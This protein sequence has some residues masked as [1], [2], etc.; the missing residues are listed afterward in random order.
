[1][2][3]ILHN[4]EQILPTLS[5]RTDFLLKTNHTLN[6]TAIDYIYTLPDSF[7]CFLRRECRGIKFNSTTGKLLARPFHKFFNLGEKPE[8]QPDQLD[9]SLPHTV[10]T[11]LDGSMVHPCVL[12]GTDQLI[13]MTRAG[14]TDIA[15]KALELAETIPNLLDFCRFHLSHHQTPIFEYTAPD[16]RIVLAYPHPELTL[17]AL[18]DNLTGSYLHLN[19]LENLP[20]PLTSHHETILDLAHFT[21]T[22]RALKN[23]EGFVIRFESGL[24]IKLKA[25]DYVLRHRAKDKLQLEKNALRI[26][27]ENADDDLLPLLPPQDAAALKAYAADV[28]KALTLLIENAKTTLATLNLPD[29]KSVAI[30]IKGYPQIQQILI[31][32]ILSTNNPLATLTDYLIK[33]TSSGPRIEAIRAEVG[34]PAWSSYWQTR[35]E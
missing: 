10:M 24:T 11:K 25:D 8:T 32:N 17:L 28:R 31:F 27:L 4:I 16:N 23:S 34:L 1:M 5:G 21:T 29:R 22:T 35:E 26:V 7:D 3:P 30:A 6:I 20:V 33:K 12:P 19:K 9:L 13:F 14:K 2:F 15:D 18:R